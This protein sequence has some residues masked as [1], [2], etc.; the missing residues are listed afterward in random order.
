MKIKSNKKVTETQF[1]VNMVMNNYSLRRGNLDGKD[2]LIA[3]VVLLKEGVHCGMDGIPTYYPANQ[4][5]KFPFTWNGVPITVGHPVTEE[6]FPISANSPDVL[7]K[8]AVG[9]LFNVTFTDSKLKGEVWIDEQK[10]KLHYP[11]LY[12]MLSNKA[13]VEVSTGLFSEDEMVY[14]LWNEEEYERIISEVRPDHLALL[15]GSIGACSFSDGCGIR[16]NKKEGGETM[17][18][19]N[20][21][22]S[23]FKVNNG[24]VFVES[25]EIENGISLLQKFFICESLSYNEIRSQVQAEIDKLDSSSYMHYLVDIYEDYFIYEAIPMPTGQPKLY[26]RNFSFNDN[27]EISVSDEI[28]EVVKKITYNPKQNKEV[29]NME[30]KGCCT[31]RVKE[32]IA[33]EKTTF[34]KEDEAWLLGLS[35]EVL[36][37]VEEMESANREKKE[38]IEALQKAAE[39]GAAELTPEPKGNQK[40]EPKVK[41]PEEFIATA[42]G[43]MRD[44][45]ANGLAMYRKKKEEA[46]KTI[47]ANKNNSFSEAQLRAMDINALEGIVRLTGTKEDF[48]GN[49][50]ANI[51]D[52]SGEVNEEPLTIPEMSYDKK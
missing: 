20:V 49:A 50:G 12:A 33:N 7:H 44:V 23:S 26:K 40:E 9:R 34:K 18:F 46:V 2:Y 17:K 48:S 39:K 30:K 21:D 3:P 16:A 10:I 27:G 52:N 22:L 11:E 25:G 41:T 8:V 42:P 1:C 28:S 13:Q 37:K 14:G 35:E 5:A 31:D 36:A 47:M 4:L 15:P 19:K 43:E 29:K 51:Q 45:L 38:K 24:K 32:L 6:G